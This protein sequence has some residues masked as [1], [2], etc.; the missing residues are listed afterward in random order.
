MNALEPASL[1]DAF[2]AHP[3]EGFSSLRISTGA[4]D[5]PAFL[6]DF[7]V[8][9]TLDDEHRWIIDLLVRFK[10]KRLARMRTV[11]SGTTVTE[12]STYP[13]MDADPGGCRRLVDRLLEAAEASKARLMIIKDLPNNSPLLSDRENR[14]ADEIARA[15][16]EDGRFIL[17]EGQALAYVPI[18]FSTID[19]YLARAS[20]ARRRDLRRKLR[21]REGLCIETVPTGSAFEDDTL[22]RSLYQQY[23]N[24]YNR[25]KYHFDKLSPQFFRATLTN[26][27]NG[28]V[29]FLYRKAGGLI[30]FNIGFQYN[31]RLIDKYVGFEYPAAREANLYFLSWFDNLEYA[32]AHGLSHYIAGCA[33][34]EVKAYLGARFT[35]SRHVVYVRNPLLRKVFVPLSR[36]FENDAS[37][38]ESQS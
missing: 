33:S 19:E 2:G 27:T 25:S 5:A 8:L 18:D 35:T 15:C 10:L 21:S 37:W 14:I 22:V 23:L 4:G 12:Y 38:T 36:F 6:T 20:K 32:L 31:G 17:V 34:P 1:A 11:F 7:D 29:V 13:A 9:T 26:G 3:P 28:G 24:V 16:V 30:G